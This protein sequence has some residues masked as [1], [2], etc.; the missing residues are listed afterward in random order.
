[1]STSE[2]WYA[3]RLLNIQKRKLK[4]ILQINRLYAISLR[5]LKLGKTLEIGCGVGRIL[6]YIPNSTGVDHNSLS[7]AYARNVGCQAF[8]VEE[9]KE[10]MNHSNEVSPQELFD[11]IIFPHVIEHL[12]LLE[13]REIV[14]DYLRYLKEDG[15]LVFVCP[16]ES[17]YK[18]DSTHKQFYDADD[19]I[20]LGEFF[21][22]SLLSKFSFPLPRVFGKFLRFNETTVQMKRLNLK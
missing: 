1:M 5:R 6:R 7:I 8:T 10:F 12:N 20:A 9:F 19:L 13:A 2:D 11:S 18:S 3:N 21:G 22:F 15:S 16:Q 4:E 14:S 17:G